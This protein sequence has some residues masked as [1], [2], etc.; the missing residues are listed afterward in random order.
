M[1]GEPLH[2][3]DPVSQFADPRL[4]NDLSAKAHR[5]QARLQLIRD[6]PAQRAT[7]ARRV[8]DAVALIMAIGLFLI[9][10][11]FVALILIIH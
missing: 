8:P 6:L 1:T 11:I 9:A 4:I 10:V 5:P 7:R 2:E 3:D